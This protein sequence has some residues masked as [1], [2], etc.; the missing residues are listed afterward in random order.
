[1]IKILATTYRTA[2]TS[3]HKSHQNCWFAR[4]ENCCF[5]NFVNL[6]AIIQIT[7]TVWMHSIMAVSN[8]IY[9]YLSRCCSWQRYT[10]SSIFYRNLR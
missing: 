4:I 5:D 2:S 6:P 9:F 3:Y 7:H 10:S 1:V 8:S